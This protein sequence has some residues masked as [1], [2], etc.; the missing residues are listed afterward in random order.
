MEKIVIDLNG[1]KGNAF[2]L[3]GLARRLAGHL[4]RD[5][6]S[7]QQEMMESDYGYLLEVFNR[8]FGDFVEL[9]N[10]P[11]RRKAQAGGAAQAQGN[12]NLR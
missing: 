8:E 4:G 3:L 2:Y 7:I 12:G 9:R 11:K 1:P 10:K 6:D 5:A